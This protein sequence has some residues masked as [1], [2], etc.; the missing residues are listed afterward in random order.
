MEGRTNLQATNTPSWLAA[1]MAALADIIIHDRVLEPSA[2]TGAIVEAVS[3]YAQNITAIELNKPMFAELVE[4][5][6]SVECLNTN[7]LRYSFDNLFDRVVM[8]PPHKN[9][10]EHVRHAADQL[11]EGGRLVALLHATYCDE[12]CKILPDVR[13]YHLPR[14]T[15]VI[16]DNY[17]EAVIAV[18]DKI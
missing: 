8:N 3:V 4:S 11:A 16:G 1:D 6:P 5:Y 14:E 15:F 7:F 17:I 12:I 10:V 2:G 9:C 18:W 13:F